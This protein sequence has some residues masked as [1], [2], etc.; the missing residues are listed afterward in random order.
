MAVESGQVSGYGRGVVRPVGG[1][2]RNGDVVYR[3]MRNVKHTPGPWRAGKYISCVVCDKPVPEIGGSDH[4]E[5]YGG[6]LIAES[7]APQ[8]AHLIAAAPDLLEACEAAY[9]FITNAETTQE[10]RQLVAGQLYN[11]LAKAEGK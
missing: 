7:I 8:N 3:E 5:Y 4:V 9:N 6:H 1:G 10:Q 2:V 11:A